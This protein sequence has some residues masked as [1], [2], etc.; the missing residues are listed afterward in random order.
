[1]AV[2]TTTASNPLVTTVVTDTDSDLTVE[3]AAQGN[4][5]LYAVEIN[6]S[7]N[8]VDP[9]Y[10]H[11][12][13]ATS[14]TVATQHDHQLYCPA[15]TTCYYYFPVGIETSTGIM[16]YASTTPGGGN[17]AVAPTENVTVIL[18]FTAR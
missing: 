3:L 18:G 12:I 4:K 17:G 14:G 1:M 2:T 16:F 8:T 9:V 7:A 10:I 6:N 5:M 11:I 13:E 15:A